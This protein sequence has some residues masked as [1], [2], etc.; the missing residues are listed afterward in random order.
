MGSIPPTGGGGRRRSCRAREDT[1]SAISDTR[2]LPDMH[3]GGNGDRGTSQQVAEVEPAGGSGAGQDEGQ[4]GDPG[5]ED[6]AH[7]G[8]HGQLGAESVASLQ[9]EAAEEQQEA[10][11]DVQASGG[12]CHTAEVLE[13]QVQ[14][15]HVRR[16]DGH[17]QEGHEDDEEGKVLIVE[18]DAQERCH[19]DGDREPSGAGP[20]TN[21]DDTEE[22]EDLLS[23]A[24]S[25]GRDGGNDDK[26][27]RDVVGRAFPHVDPSGKD[28]PTECDSVDSVEQAM[29]R[30]S[31]M[32]TA[33]QMTKFESKLEET[34]AWSAPIW[35]C[36]SSR[37]VPRNVPGR[38]DDATSD[39]SN[40]SSS[41]GSRR[42][43]TR[44]TTRIE[45][46]S[47]ARRMR[48]CPP[49]PGRRPWRGWRRGR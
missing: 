12:H 25:L 32:T 27:V 8:E 33:R 49:C 10:L 24:A 5:A 40:S 46:G 26:D 19:G 47:S 9:P 18:D 20:G 36:S 42:L 4:A 34:A 31:M 38:A 3:C 17:D 29:M 35:S 14:A 43:L 41:R 28:G 1:D 21:P 15:H 48:P 2:H 16:S 39:N 22:A 30:V 13:T 44:R 6:E 23:A 37:E 11:D 45:A 7:E